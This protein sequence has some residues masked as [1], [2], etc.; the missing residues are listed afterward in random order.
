M[1]K[2]KVEREV[3]VLPLSLYTF[4]FVIGPIFAAPLSE[5]YGR[6]IIYWTTLPLLLIF[7]AIAGVS[8]NIT[9]LTINRFLAAVLGSGS[10]AVGAGISLL[11]L[12]FLHYLTQTQEPSRISGL[13]LAVAE[14]L[15][16]L[17]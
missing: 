15:Y 7:T 11:L 1:A 4:G 9:Q 16:S 2:F 17:P 13:Q 14:P 5:L 12:Y 6:R 3:A 10:L 8:N